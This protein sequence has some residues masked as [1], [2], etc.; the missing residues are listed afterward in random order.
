M[1]IFAL[2][3]TRAFGERVATASGVA[4]AEIDERTFPDGE[5][6][7]RPVA[8]PRGRDVYVIQSLHAS[9]EASVSDKLLRLLMFLE[10][11]R[12]SGAR[13]TTAVIPY[14]AFARQDRQVRPRDPLSLKSAALL[15][16]AVGIDA[17]VTIDVH[18]IAAFQ[19]AF[20]CR[21]VELTARRDFARKAVEIGLDDPVVVGSPDLGGVKRAQLFAKA[22]KEIRDAPVR[23][24]IM[25][26]QR[27]DGDIAGTQF[28]GDVNGAHVLILDD[29]ISTGST[30]L[31][32]V[33]ACRQRGARRI[34]AFAT[35]GLFSGDASKRLMPPGLEKIVVS[36]TVPPFR[37]AED[38]AR[39]H[40]EAVGVAPLFAAA[41]R[42]LHESR[43]LDELIQ[44]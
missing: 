35:H 26:K 8:S 12:D 5:F 17:V 9:P 22:L 11:V 20:R 19:N 37:L 29:M 42:N 33:D 40:I 10:T 3:E 7:A 24:A 34:D 39:K 16:E 38:L 6:Q 28:A 30:L 44:D 18:N 15:L 1:L 4:L 43:S 32:A 41:I 21:T 36:D 13:R 14:L 25:E 27:L 2:G 31:R 23:L